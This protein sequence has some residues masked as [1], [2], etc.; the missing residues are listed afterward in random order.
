[1]PLPVNAAF[2]AV[3]L[4]PELMALVIPLLTGKTDEAETVRLPPTMFLIPGVIRS[5]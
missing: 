1:M 2:G 5:G 4:G 3:P